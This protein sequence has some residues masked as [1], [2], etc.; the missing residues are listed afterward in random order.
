MFV[1]LVPSLWPCV[2]PVFF[3]HWVTASW[4]YRPLLGQVGG[5]FIFF[6]FLNLFAGVEVTASCLVV[7]SWN[8]GS[9]IF[10]VRKFKLA[11]HAY[12]SQSFGLFQ[13]LL[14]AW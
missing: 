1:M 2:T 3:F 9:D 8:H 6:F 7:N 10:F 12:I 14:T 4:V 13:P 5:F 11:V